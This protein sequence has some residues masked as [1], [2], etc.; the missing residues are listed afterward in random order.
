TISLGTF[1]D[2]LV[3]GAE[4]Y[5]VALANPGSTTGANVTGT[6]SQA[7]TIND[8]DTATWSLTGSGTVT[9]GAAASYTPALSGTLQQNETATIDLSIAFPGGTSGAVAADFTNA[10]LTDGDT[11]FAAYN[12]AGPGTLSRSSNTL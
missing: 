1:N 8:N 10:F 7:T 4:S 11:A 9:E 5:T 2:T 6:G 3:E 12:A